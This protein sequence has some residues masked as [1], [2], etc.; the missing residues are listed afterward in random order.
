M[1]SGN[2]VVLSRL[3]GTQAEAPSKASCRSMWAQH[4]GSDHE[5]EMSAQTLALRRHSRRRVFIASLV[6]LRWVRF[7]SFDSLN[8]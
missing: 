4:L 1:L 7:D 6:Y 5:N 2:V 8:D 3:L